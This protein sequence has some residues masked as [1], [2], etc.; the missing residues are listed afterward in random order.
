MAIDRWRAGV[1]M[2]MMAQGEDTVAE[3]IGR[4]QSITMF[5]FMGAAATAVTSFINFF[6][7]LIFFPH[8]RRRTHLCHFQS[9][10]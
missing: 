2:T 5:E 3:M 9:G 10:E 7:L 4:V 6:R 8:L 1:R